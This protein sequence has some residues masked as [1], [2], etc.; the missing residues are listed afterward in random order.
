MPSIRV[1]G[2]WSLAALA[3][4]A[5]LA[6][7]AAADVV[8]LVPARDNTLYEQVDGTLSN[9]AGPS[10]F[11]GRTAQASN[12][13]R[14]G[15][16]AFDIAA[17]V[18]AGAVI[19]AAVLRLSLTASSGGTFAVSLHRVSAS[20]GEG[21]SNAGDSGG[22]GAPA[23]AGDATWKHRAFPGTLWAALGGDCAAAA[24][25]SLPVGAPGDYTWGSSPAMVADVQAWLDTPANNHGWLVRGT[26]SSQPTA[27]RFES[28]QSTAPEMRPLLTIEYA[29]A[30]PAPAASWGRIKA[31]YR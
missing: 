13:I 12:S 2:S 3:V 1:P 17:A 5:L 18:P 14:R 10:F 11:A 16:V 22:G 26:E 31:G 30:T 25:A 9:G 15:L 28:R 29:R 24:S 27:R 23:E 19:T 4:A 7:P 20:W 6:P 21:A 8:G